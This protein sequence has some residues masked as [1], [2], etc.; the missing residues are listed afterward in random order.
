M[1]PFLKRV[2]DVYKPFR[3]KIIATF[4]FLAVGECI[5][6]VMPFLYGLVINLL[7]GGTPLKIVMVVAGIVYVAQ[8]LV[9]VISMFREVYEIRNID[10]DIGNSISE[11]TLRKIMALSIGQ[12]RGQNSSTIISVVSQGES[13]LRNV[14]NMVMYEIVPLAA[15][16]LITVAVIMI[17]SWQIGCI[18]IFGGACF[19]LITYVIEKKF[20]PQIKKLDDIRHDI[21]REYGDIVGNLTLVQ[22]HCKETAVVEEYVRSMAKFADSGKNMWISFVRFGMLRPLVMHFMRFLTVAVGAYLVYAGHFKAGTL[23]TLLMWSGNA[24]ANFGRIGNIHRRFTQSMVSLKKYF[25]VLDLEPA[26]KCSSDP[27]RPD[28]LE[29][30]IEFQGVS[31]KYPRGGYIETDSRKIEGVSELAVPALEDVSFVIEPGQ[32]V[33]LV[34][35]SGAGKSTIITMIL[36]GYDPD[37]GQILVDGHDLRKLDLSWFRSNIGYVEQNV[38][39]FDRTM[40]YNIAFGSSDCVHDVSDADL[41]RIAVESCI[42]RFKGRLTKGWETKIGENGIELSGGE[43]QRVGIARALIKKPAI[44]IFDEATSNLDAISESAIR[45]SIRKAATGRTT[46]VIAHRLST[47]IDADQIIVVS[48]GKVVAQGTHDELLADSPEYRTLVETQLLASVRQSELV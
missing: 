18:V 32:M 26:V 16:F 45:D 9:S 37:N 36:R 46:I 33:A 15:Q 35:E 14:A 6:L 22:V 1:N 5:A 27:V 24:M 17:V 19:I 47:V 28:R 34:G 20:A 39:L 42:D 43:R 44:L 41:D 3:R 40:R 10:Y 13:A 30:R 12:H 21:A 31:F 38:G 25:S 4:G 23:V 11:M 8:V 7:I 2:C 48:G 29:G